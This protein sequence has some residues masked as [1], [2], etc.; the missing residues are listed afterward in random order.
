VTLA[1]APLHGGCHCGKLTLELT[2]A[3]SPANM[4]PRA[5]DCAFCTKHGAGWVSDAEGRLAIDVQAADMADG[6][7]QGSGSARFLLCRDCGVLV[8]VVHDHA[9]GLRGAANV[10]CL[11]DAAM[12]GNAVTV[13]PQQLSREDKIARWGQLWTPT[14]V[15]ARQ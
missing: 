2:T 13:S 10:R 11:D 6:Y 7:R 9:E 14:T 3:R 1:P 15:Q 12:F 4:H 8:A 5:C